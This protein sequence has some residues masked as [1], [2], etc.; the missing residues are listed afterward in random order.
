MRSVRPERIRP[1]RIAANAKLQSA[2]CGTFH[3]L[4]AGLA[5]IEPGK[6]LRNVVAMENV[7][8]AGDPPGVTLGGTN[9]AVEAAGNPDAANVIALEN[10][11][12]PGVIVIVYIAV[13]PAVTVTAAPGPLSAKSCAKVVRSFAVSLVTITSPPPDTVAVF[14]TFPG[15][16]P[17]VTVSVMAG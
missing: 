1:S 14:V 16:V 7:V 4:G 5:G 15:V 6:A 13:C 11:P 2:N 12:G 9:V 10:P 3:G 8:V 17:T